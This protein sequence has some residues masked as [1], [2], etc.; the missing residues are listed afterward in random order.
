[1]GRFK[2]ARALLGRDDFSVQPD[3]SEFEVLGHNFRNNYEVAVDS[4]GNVWQSDNDDDG[5]YGV[6]IN[7]VLEGGNYG[8]LEEL[9]GAGWRNTASARRRMSAHGTGT[10]TTRACAQLCPAG[11]GSPTGITVYEGELLPK[12]FHNQV[13][14]CDAG[15]G[16]GGRPRPSRTAAVSPAR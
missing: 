2:D 15:P 14:H 5:N 16:V 9:T 8:Y 6:R 11:A 1:M 13:I 7:Y 12:V 3:G 10:R 4:F